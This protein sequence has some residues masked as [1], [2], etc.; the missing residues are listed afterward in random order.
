MGKQGTYIRTEE[1]KKNMSEAVKNSKRHILAVSDPVY[2]SKMR[3]SALSRNVKPPVFIGEK[4]W[5]YGLKKHENPLFKGYKYCSDCGKQL[6]RRTAT[7]CNRCN[8]L[9]KTTPLFRQIR[10]IAEYIKWRC[11][12]LTRDNFICQECGVKDV[13]LEA[14]H[15]KSFVKILRDKKIQSI[16]EAKQ[17][18]ELWD[19]HNGKT[20][21]EE[22]HKDK[23]KR[24]SH[25]IETIENTLYIS[26]FL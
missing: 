4:H 15:K 10:N 20:L 3:K 26:D 5:T 12:V 18:E 16:E 11:E 8:K 21:C 14:H 23:R 13:K 19:I 7:K 22:C 17:C 1:Y 25:H 6:A 24:K 2:K 9:K